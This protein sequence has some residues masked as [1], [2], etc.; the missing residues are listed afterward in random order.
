MA[1]LARYYTDSSGRCVSNPSIRYTTSI[2][3]PC[4]KAKSQSNRSR[5]GKDRWD[6]CMGLTMLAV[7][8]VRLVDMLF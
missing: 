4:P 5:G 3:K 1:H 6:M 7:C 8:Q 2:R